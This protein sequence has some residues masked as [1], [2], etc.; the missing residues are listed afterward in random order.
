MK[1]QDYYSIMGIDR[2][3]SGAEIKRAYHILARRFHPD[4]SLDPDGESKFKL[5]AEAYRTL[6]CGETRSAYNR[7]TLQVYGGSAWTTDPLRDWR[8]F[9]PWMNWVWVW[10]G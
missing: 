1:Q 2:G 8:A 6:K 5:V 9:F 7:Q 3:A 10:P 4:V